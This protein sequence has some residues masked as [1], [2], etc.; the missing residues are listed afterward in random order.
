MKRKLITK[1]D[2]HGITWTDDIEDLLEDINRKGDIN[3]W[4]FSS[5]WFDIRHH[6]DTNN[7]MDAIIWQLLVNNIERFGFRFND[8]REAQLDLHAAATFIGDTLNGVWWQTIVRWLRGMGL[9]KTYGVTVND[10][11]GLNTL[12]MVLKKETTEY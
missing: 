12:Y 5:W 4:Y 6:E 7:A 1:K 2:L 8:G 3:G 9:K 11:Y 10:I